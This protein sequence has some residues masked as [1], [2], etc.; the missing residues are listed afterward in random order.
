MLPHCSPILQISFTNQP[1]K[2]V[3]WKKD[4]AIYQMKMKIYK[5]DDT[6]IVR[7]LSGAKLTYSSLLTLDFGLQINLADIT[8]KEN[9]LSYT[10]TEAEVAHKVFN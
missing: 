1:E 4:R 10:V 9:F 5:Y 7:G 6:R 2:S 3:K 8:K